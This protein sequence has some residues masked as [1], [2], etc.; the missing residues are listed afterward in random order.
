MDDNKKAAKNHWTLSIKDKILDKQP[1]Y[2]PAFHVVYLNGN[3]IDGVALES[4]STP[5]D[6]IRIKKKTTETR[7]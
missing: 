1:D 4:T 5:F 2:D 7:T 3:Q 6:I